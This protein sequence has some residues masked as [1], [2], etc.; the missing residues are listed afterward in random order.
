VG[1]FQK[2]DKEVFCEVYL[3]PGQYIVYVQID[4][5]QKNTRP[6]T[7]TSYGIDGAYF[8][9]LESSSI[10]NFLYLIFSDKARRSEHK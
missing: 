9:L 1:G 4:W 8:E 7:L 10:S 2:A 6:F 5:Y 3:N